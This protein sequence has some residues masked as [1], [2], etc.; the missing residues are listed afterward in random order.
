MEVVLLIVV[1]VVLVVV[2]EFGHFIAA[3]L[4]GM[5]VDEFGIGYPPRITGFRYGET[6]YTL[7]ALP[8]G[9]FVKIY[10]EDMDAAQSEPAAARSFTAKPRILQAIVLVAG[11]AMNVLF[12]F[13]LLT[14]ILAAGTPRP[15]APNEIAQAHDAKLAIA[16]A[17]PGSPA[18]L[19]GIMQGDY[20]ISATYS[21]QSFTGASPEAFTNFMSKDTTNTPVAIE[22]LRNGKHLELT[23]TPRAGIITAD[24]GRVALGVAVAT[25]GTVPLPFFSAVS[26]GLST[27]WEITKETAL[28]LIHLFVGIFTLTAD[29][30]QVSGPVGIAGAVGSAAVQGAGN[31]I[32]LTAIISI[33]LAL[34]NLLPVPALDGGRLLFV[35][36]EAII[37]RP[38]H[39][40]VAVAVN[41]AGFALLILLMLVVTAHDVY[42]LIV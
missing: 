40:K 17:L 38:I 18:A 13:L 34:I 9:G 30:S 20:L 5:R 36:I 24:P 6:E 23:A 27:T 35:I 21:G 28:G 29:L 11:I 2:H 31:L 32:S 7:N 12:A 14:G 19:A 42:K 15:L 16:Q 25:V 39:K 26:V 8:F 1:L 3:K 4:C 33:N 10:G 37:R 41:T 22:V